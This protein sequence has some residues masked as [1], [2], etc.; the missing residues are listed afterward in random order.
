VIFDRYPKDKATSLFPPNMVQIPPE[1][2]RT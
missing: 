1:T 2:R